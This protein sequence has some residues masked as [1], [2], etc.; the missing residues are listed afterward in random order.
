MEAPECWLWRRPDGLPQGFAT[1]SSK[2]PGLAN[3]LWLAMGMDA[4][5]ATYNSDINGLYNLVLMEARGAK[6]AGQPLIEVAGLLPLQRFLALLP[7]QVASTQP[8]ERAYPL[9]RVL[10][11]ERL[12][13]ADA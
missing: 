3:L 10:A 9:L 1:I 8:M 5:P 6:L 13:H 2:V 12:S 11:L 4:P 7:Q